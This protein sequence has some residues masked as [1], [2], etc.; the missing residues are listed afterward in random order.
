MAG[1]LTGSLGAP[2]VPGAPGEQ[3]PPG[4]DHRAAGRIGPRRARGC[5]AHSGLFT[6]ELAG[7][8][9]AA[10]GHVDLTDPA[11]PT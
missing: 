6:A 8:G 10:S 7:Q 11:G 4:E 5:A 2:L 3:H 9:T 1:Q